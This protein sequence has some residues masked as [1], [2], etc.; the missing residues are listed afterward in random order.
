MLC[1]RVFCSVLRFAFCVF[2]GISK[3]FQPSRSHGMLSAR[4]SLHKA[5]FVCYPQGFLDYVNPLEHLG[6]LSARVSSHWHGFGCYPQ[7]FQGFEAFSCVFDGKGK[8][9][10]RFRS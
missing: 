10:H 9:F 3:G 8:G 1:A 4:V 5:S 2:D 7:G 6:M